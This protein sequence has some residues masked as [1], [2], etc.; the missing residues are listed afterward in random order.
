MEITYNEQLLA[1]YFFNE[2]TSISDLISE[3]DPCYKALDLLD[4]WLLNFTKLGKLEGS[5]SKLAVLEHEE[6]IYVGKGASIEPFVHIK[7]PAVVMPGAKVHHGAYLRGGVLLLEGAKVGHGSEVKHSI[8]LQRASA[9]HLNYVGDSI[10]GNDVNLGS[11]ATCANLRLDKGPITIRLEEEK[12]ETERKKL[13]AILG[14]RCQVGCNSVLGPGLVVLPDSFILP[15]S[16]VTG[17]FPKRNS[18]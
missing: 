9:S 2:T 10:L 18:L 1:K 17:F 7:G 14:D 5:I 12:I 4:D 11:G 15:L 16:T 8:F 6:L 13:G 3:T